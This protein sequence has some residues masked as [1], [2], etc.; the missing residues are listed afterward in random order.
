[1]DVTGSV[2]KLHNDLLNNFYPLPDDVRV[3]VSRR[4]RWSRHVACMVE[5]GNTYRILV[6]KPE[7]MVSFEKL[8]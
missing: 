4:M 8:I 5:M 6:W 1:L 7:W 3:T 2:R